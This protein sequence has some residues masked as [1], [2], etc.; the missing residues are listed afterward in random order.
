MA[1]SHFRDRSIALH[2]IGVPVKRFPLIPHQAAKR[3][4]CSQAYPYSVPQ[5]TTLGWIDQVVPIA[6]FHPEPFSYIRKRQKTVVNENCATAS[7][8]QNS[9]K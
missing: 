5:L 9:E 3:I 8:H 7:T 2:G 6:N 4:R 1:F